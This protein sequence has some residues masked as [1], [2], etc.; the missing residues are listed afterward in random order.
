MENKIRNIDD[1]NDK[2][3][4]KITGFHAIIKDLLKTRLLPY[5]FDSKKSFDDIVVTTW[6]ILDQIY[7]LMR[8]KS[9]ESLYNAINNDWGNNYIGHQ[10][11]EET[12]GEEKV[13]NTSTDLYKKSLHILAWDFFS[14]TKVFNFQSDVQEMFSYL[15]LVTNSNDELKEVN[16]VRLILDY[17]F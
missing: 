13:E 12:K 14:A 7:S 3:A 2:L 15:E 10:Y 4:L 11:E 16:I 8:E 5:L 17:W 1:S 9:K 6:D